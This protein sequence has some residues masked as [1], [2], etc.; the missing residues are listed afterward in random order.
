MSDYNQDT[1]MSAFEDEMSKIAKGGVKYLASAAAG[2]G[3]MYAGGKTKKMYRMAKKEQREQDE[4]R[5]LK[6]M[7]AL[8]A[9]MA[10]RK[11][12]GSAFSEN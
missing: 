8:Q 1:V 5:Q 4:A 6:R 12:Y 11:Q 10:L 2:G 3:L 9:R 7:Q